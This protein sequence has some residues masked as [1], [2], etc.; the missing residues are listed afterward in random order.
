MRD[1]HRSSPPITAHLVVGPVHAG[2][3]RHVDDVADGPVLELG[4]VNRLQRRHS[5]L[6]H[7]ARFQGLKVI[8][9]C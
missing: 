9:G 6:H 8:L 2:A 1:E 5:S 4:A 3:V 7:P